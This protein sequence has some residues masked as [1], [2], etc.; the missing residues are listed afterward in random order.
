LRQMDCRVI[1]D[2]I[3]SLLEAGVNAASLARVDQLNRRIRSDI[4]DHAGEIDTWEIFI[5]S[6]ALRSPKCD[7]DSFGIV[8]HEAF[9]M[10]L[11]KGFHIHLRFL[12]TLG[13]EFRIRVNKRSGFDQPPSV[14]KIEDRRMSAKGIKLRSVEVGIV[15]I[16]WPSSLNIEVPR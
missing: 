11:R 7:D 15:G 1:P 8:S 16:W 6:T 3:Q 4:R 12:E 10:V 5:P 13:H 14:Y 9:G 2:L